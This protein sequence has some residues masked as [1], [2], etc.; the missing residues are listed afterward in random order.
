MAREYASIGV[1][2]LKV[3]SKPGSTRTTNY[4][5]LLCMH[6]TARKEARDGH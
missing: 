5:Y 1:R 4:M 2:Y 6:L 3:H